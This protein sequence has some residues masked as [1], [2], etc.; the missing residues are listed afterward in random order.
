MIYNILKDSFVIRHR[1]SKIILWIKVQSHFFQIYVYKPISN[2]ASTPN[3]KLIFKY[4][5]HSLLL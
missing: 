3:L 2:E 5:Q 4:V 1:N